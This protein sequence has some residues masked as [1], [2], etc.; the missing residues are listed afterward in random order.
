MRKLKSSLLIL[1]LLVLAFLIWNSARVGYASLLDAKAAATGNVAAANTA[2][3]LS[4]GNPEAHLLLGG[5]LEANE[6]RSAAI[7]QYQSATALRPQ[8][9]V[10]WLQLARAQELEGDSAAA[11]SSGQNAVRLA[12]FYAQPHWQLGNILVR[13]GRLEDG[14]SELRLAG[15]SDPTLLA[16]IIDLAWQL[17]DGKVDHVKQMVQPHTPETY[18]ELAEYFKKRG[19]WAEAVMMFEAAG[20][21]T[22]RERHAYIGELISAKK[23]REAH[24]LWSIAHPP[25]P[26]GP[27]LFDA[28]FEQESDL[29]EP[30]FGWHATN[31]PNSL[32]LSLDNSNPKEGRLSL[33]VDFNGESN[34]NASIISQLV[35]LEPKTR[36][37]LRLDFR[38]ENLVSGGLPTI[39]IL[40]ANDDKVLGQT[41]PLPQTTDG[42]HE[43]AIDFTTLES[44]TAIQIALHR[45]P[46]STPECPIFGRLWLDDFFLNGPSNYVRRR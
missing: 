30:G 13:A 12:P 1:T 42:W 14:F 25:D 24:T 29:D 18:K 22:D 38:T 35:L 28:G 41:E 33:R 32:T 15:A 6:D 46:C 37:Q 40:D 5:L 9:Y 2:V 20:S 45:R 11:I 21:S 16:P 23:F 3:S 39:L 43:T 27:L 10:L 7:V 8:D 19:Q 36:Y 34:P 4:P 17:S 26:D 44:T 31:P